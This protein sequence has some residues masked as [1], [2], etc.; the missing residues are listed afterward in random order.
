MKKHKPSPIELAVAPLRADAI[1]RAKQEAETAITNMR[2]KLA[3]AGGDI[4]KV[5]PYP[6]GL[7]GMQYYVGRER[8][9][10]YH[11]VTIDDP[12]HGYQRSTIGNAPYFVVFDEE[13]VQRYIT[14]RMEDAAA[15]YDA[16]VKKLD[17]KIGKVKTATLHGNHVWGYSTLVVTKAGK[18]TEAWK[19]Q[20]IVNC[21]KLG[22][23][24]NQWPTRQMKHVPTL[25]LEKAA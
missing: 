25:A 8:Y 17:A 2:E 4:N 24:F 16:F 6:R 3:E 11:A 5:A 10:R 13:R 15:D 14:R 23:L 9:N 19:T 1:E 21:S 22:K 7:Y 12:A 20:Q 18:V